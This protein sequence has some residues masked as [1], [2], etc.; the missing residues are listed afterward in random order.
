MYFLLFSLIVIGLYIT[1][2]KNIILDLP[3]IMLLAEILMSWIHTGKVGFE[4]TQ[5]IRMIYFSLIFAIF[6][7]VFHFKLLRPKF[8]IFFIITILFF[9]IVVFNSTVFFE[10]FKKYLRIA[11]SFL[12]FP[13][14]YQYFQRNQHEFMKFYKRLTIYNAI[15]IVPIVI[16][17]I[18]KIGTPWGYGDNKIVYLIGFNMWGLYGIIYSVCLTLFI[19]E[20]VKYK[21]YKFWNIVLAIIL[22]TLLIL[23]FKRTLVITFFIGVFLYLITVTSIDKRRYVYLFFLIIALLLTY[24]FYDDVV[25]QA[26]FSRERIFDLQNYAEEGRVLELINYFRIWL[27][28]ESISTIIFGKDFFYSGYTDSFAAVSQIF[29]QR[30]RI[31]HSDI[32]NLLY[33]AG[34]F[35]AFLFL[36]YLFKYFKA[37][38]ILKKYSQTTKRVYQFMLI[39]VVLNLFSEGM[40]QTMNYFMFFAITGALAG[41]LESTHAQ[42]KG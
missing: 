38:N 31:I 30:G 19:S 32:A 27:Q 36:L 41:Y 15:F 24:Q 13:V 18:L 37:I 1:K 40:D 7:F 35:G 22:A 23:I 39:T 17:S 20:L 6:V 21:K 11:P 12:A 14:Y 16:S 3:I 26:V 8:R 33:T 9:I 28:E 34:I 25:K 42:K 10:S 5:Q 29:G 4:T 2:N